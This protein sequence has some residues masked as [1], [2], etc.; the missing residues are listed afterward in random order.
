MNTVEA[1]KE[2]YIYAEYRANKR[3]EIC[4]LVCRRG[5]GGD[6]EREKVQLA[7]HGEEA[8]EGSAPLHCAL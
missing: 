3:C 2:Q 6:R 7:H 1:T 4:H 5:G 8:A